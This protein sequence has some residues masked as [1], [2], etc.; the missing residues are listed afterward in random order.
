MDVRSLRERSYITARE[1][2]EDLME[3]RQNFF[4][5]RRGYEIFLIPR[6]G[7]LNFFQD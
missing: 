2:L 5:N 7:V 4:V 6:E 3:G 1:G